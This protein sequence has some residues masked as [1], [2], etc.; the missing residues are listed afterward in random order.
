MRLGG[1]TRSIGIICNFS[2]S[3][4]LCSRFLEG[5]KLTFST[6]DS[7]IPADQRKKKI[8]SIGSERVT[9][10]VS[11]K[12]LNEQQLK[13][14]LLKLDITLMFDAET[15]P[16]DTALTTLLP[17][18]KGKKNKIVYVVGR[19]TI[20]SSK[21]EKK[22][23]ECMTTDAERFMKNEA[24]FSQVMANP[25]YVSMQEPAF[26]NS[27]S[28]SNSSNSKFTKATFTAPT[29]PEITLDDPN[30]WSKLLPQQ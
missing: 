17:E 18:L 24:L 9:Y 26:S 6:I 15:S 23:I 14:L 10:L 13:E 16:I 11:P 27:N 4:S 5:R 20:E 21:F 25:K 29:N 28:N 7:S 12:S 1:S 3:I 22:Q 30:F 19:H 2:D 8:E